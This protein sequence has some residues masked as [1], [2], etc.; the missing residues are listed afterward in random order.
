MGKEQDM[1]RG[2]TWAGSITTVAVVMTFTILAGGPLVSTPAAAAEITLTYA[3]FPPAPTFPCVQ[4]E[5]WAKQV[6]E[7]TKG[8]V[9]VKTFPGGTLLGA[10]QMF[11]GIIAGQ[12]D[13]GCVILASQPGRFPVVSAVDLPVGF[14]KAETATK[15]LLDV[16]DKYQPTSMKKVKVLALFTCPPAN[17]MAK[18]EI[19]DLRDLSG[20]ELRSNGAWV[21]VLKLLGAK[22]IAM[23]LSEAPEALQKGIVKGIFS[24]LEILKDF[25][26]AA[27]LP[28][29]TVMDGP[30]GSF[31]V[32]MNMSKWNSLPADVKKVLEGMRREHS[33]WTGKYADAHV[34]ESLD[35]SKK[36][37]Q[38]TVYDLSAEQAGKWQ[39]RLKPIQEKW[40]KDAEAKKLPGKE[41][42]GTVVK[43]K[44]EYQ[45]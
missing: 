15:V 11:D 30:V 32:F 43:L 18:K 13:I 24:S 44:E 1:S 45:K 40:V 36:K 23:P 22:P 12:A 7:K 38:I 25:K 5:R 3:N 9:D 20:L 41:I 39:A 35:W 8:K 31:G 34:D 28:Y 17:I 14:K 6:R 26:F 42:L 37:Y 19:K 16:Y 33:V 4:M 27:S 10:R 2:K 29:V 21:P